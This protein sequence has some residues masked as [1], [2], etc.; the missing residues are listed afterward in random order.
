MSDFYRILLGCHVGMGAL[1][2]LT[3]WG[4]VL[5]RKGSRRHLRFGRGFAVSMALTAATAAV[6]CLLLLLDPL[7]ARPPGPEIAPGELDEYVQVLREVGAGLLEVSL[8]T[9]AFLYFGLR[10]LAG[11]RGVTP[12]GL[13]GDLCV[14]CATTSAG[15]V[16]LTLGLDPELPEFAG[17]G[18][19]LG[20]LGALVI[21]RLLRP[22][23]SPAS[24]LVRH[25]V[26][27][28]GA[29]AIAHGAFATNVAGLFTD[30]LRTA[31]RWGGLTSLLFAVAIAWTARR[32]KLRIEGAQAEP[33]RATALS[34][35][36]ARA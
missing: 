11:R 23:D 12:H 8:A 13:A 16:M 9:G 19:F 6:L 34:A 35:R 18:I 5:F 36:T 14:A 4:A 3:F 24:W 25:L 28:L 2:L 10:A 27:M 17:N 33:G 31:F 32:W 15:L 30:D 29:G 7:A 21:R 1:A 26:G 20:L 22:S